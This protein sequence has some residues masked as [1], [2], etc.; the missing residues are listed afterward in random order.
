MKQC[1]KITVS[2]NVQNVGYR[3]FIQEYAQ[4][5]KVEGTAQNSENGSVI[6]Y[7][8]G[9]TDMLDE[10]IDML[11]KGPSKA[12]IENVAAEPFMTEKDFRGVFRIIG[13]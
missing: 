5:L 6:I 4:K 3:K 1:L 7:A 10:F 12:D 8:S 11:Y 13:E 9:P 2:G